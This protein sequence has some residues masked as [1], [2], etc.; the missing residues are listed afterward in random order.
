MYIYS[1]ASIYANYTMSCLS[2]T[3]TTLCDAPDNVTG[4]FWNIKSSIISSII[5]KQFELGMVKAQ[6]GSQI[7]QYGT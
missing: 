1:L 7:E 3:L 4:V 5:K 6:I 2:F